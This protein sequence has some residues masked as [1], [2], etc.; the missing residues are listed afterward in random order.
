MIRRRC[1]KCGAAS[2][3]VRPA[4]AEY[5]GRAGALWCAACGRHSAPIGL[6]ELAALVD[7]V[8]PALA[9]RF[10]KNCGGWVV[11]R[12][13]RWAAAALDRGVP[14]APPIESA[15]DL[16]GA[17]EVACTLPRARRGCPQFARRLSYAIG[18]NRAAAVS[19]AAMIIAAEITILPLEV[20]ALRPPAPAAAAAQ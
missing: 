7:G 4:A 17:L 16:I 2:F 8:Y 9:E 11:E 19:W 5:R 18:E 14:C 12:A 20:S 15:A 1:Q 6:A 13:E 3:H 10:A